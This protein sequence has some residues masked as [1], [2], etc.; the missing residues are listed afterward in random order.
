M[1]P[2]AMWLRN[3]KIRTDYDEILIGRSFVSVMHFV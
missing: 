1:A 3:T 2:T